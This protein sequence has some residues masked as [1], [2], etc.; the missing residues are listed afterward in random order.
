MLGYA[1]ASKLFPLFFGV[2][3]A[4]WAGWEFVRTRKIDP[5]L[6]RFAAGVGRRVRA[7]GGDLVGD[8]RPARVARL[9]RA[10]RRRPARAL[11][12]QPVFVQDRVPAGGL[13][14]PG[15]IRA[16]LDVAGARSRRRAPR[17][18]CTSGAIPFFLLQLALTA[19]VALGLRRAEP[20]EA[21]AVGPLLVYV[22]LVVNAYY[23][24]M[25]ALTALAWARAPSAIGWCRCSACTPC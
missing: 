2:G 11:L 15:R 25:L 6:Y 1:I 18:T 10:H 21:L 24:N 17:S 3:F 16:Q 9:P 14:A 20:I 23:W 8:V 19:L 22:W 4:F 7:V 12:R 13:V 5:R